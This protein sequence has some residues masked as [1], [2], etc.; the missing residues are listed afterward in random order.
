[1][2]KITFVAIA[3]VMFLT[4]CVKQEDIFRG[5]ERNFNYTPSYL[6]PRMI[7]VPVDGNATINVGGQNFTVRCI[8]PSNPTADGIVIDAP[9]IPTQWEWYNS[10]GAGQYRPSNFQYNTGSGFTHEFCS[11]YFVEV[12]TN[13]SWRFFNGNQVPWGTVPNPSSMTALFQYPNTW[14]KTLPLRA[15]VT[16]VTPNR[17]SASM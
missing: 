12:Y 1:M 8:T 14:V 5:E 10:D 7:G 4:S 11:V 2:K 13:G 16:K 9:M 6:Q 15:T 17:Y 3:A